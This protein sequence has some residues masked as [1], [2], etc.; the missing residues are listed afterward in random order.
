MS[1]KSFFLSH[2]LAHGDPCVTWPLAAKAAP[3]S[4]AHPCPLRWRAWRCSATHFVPC[5]SCHFDRAG[6]TPCTLALQSWTC[7]MVLPLGSYSCVDV[8]CPHMGDDVPLREH[9]PES[10]TAAVAATGPNIWGSWARCPLFFPVHR[11]PLL[12]LCAS[13]YLCCVD[14]GRSGTGNVGPAFLL[15]S[16]W[17]FVL[18][19]SSFSAQL[20]GSAAHH[21]WRGPPCPPEQGSCLQLRISEPRTPHGML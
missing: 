8:S 20:L 17:H 7:H 12:P 3:V 6:V 19:S 13:V 9:S 11:P 18:T 10:L 14:P 16:L 5:P 2:S 4:P 15:E 21:C 1:F